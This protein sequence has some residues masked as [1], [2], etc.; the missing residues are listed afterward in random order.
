MGGVV[1]V[2]CSLVVVVG[3]GVVVSVVSVARFVSVL[4]VVVVVVLGYRHC[5][6]FRGLDWMESLRIH[7]KI[8]RTMYS[9]KEDNQ[10]DYRSLQRMMAPLRASNQKPQNDHKCHV[11]RRRVASGGSTIRN[12]AVASSVQN[13]R[14]P[15]S[16]FPTVLGTAQNAIFRF[17]VVRVCLFQTRAHGGLR[18]NLSSE[19]QELRGWAPELYSYWLLVYGGIGLLGHGE[20][21]GPCGHRRWHQCKELSP[22]SCRCNAPSRY[23]AHSCRGLR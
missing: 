1:V 9:L 2:T 23:A 11:A 21:M 19:A 20:C 3:M 14:Y 6:C 17:T 13:R 16:G 7:A 15:E 5:C 8:F 10:Q 22:C 12:V 4:M 18:R